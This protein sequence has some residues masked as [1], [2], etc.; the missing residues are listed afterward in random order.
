MNRKI[1]YRKNVFDCSKNFL[2]LF[3]KQFECGM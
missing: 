2:R 3:K 1:G